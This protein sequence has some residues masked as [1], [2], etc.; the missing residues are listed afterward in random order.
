MGIFF[1]GC[2]QDLIFDFQHFEYDVSRHF[3]E[4]GILTL[5]GVLR[6]SQIC[7]LMPFIVLEKFSAIISSNIFSIP[8]SLSSEIACVRLFDIRSA[9]LGCSVF[10]L[11][12]LCFS[13]GDF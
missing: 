8:F 5:L 6:V 10:S 1:F 4:W 3:S 12:S 7:G 11:F 13:L 9:D 2:V